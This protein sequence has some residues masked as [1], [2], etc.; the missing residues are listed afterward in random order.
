LG[1]SWV[2]KLNRRHGW[3]L[4]AYGGKGKKKNQQRVKIKKE[5]NK[6]RTNNAIER[7]V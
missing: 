7:K 6:Y 4:V 2:S 1:V 3:V 5:G